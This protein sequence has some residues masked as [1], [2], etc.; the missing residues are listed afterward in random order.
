MTGICELLD[1]GDETRPYTAA[2]LA[3]REKISDSALTPSARLLAELQAGGEDFFA[4]G[5]RIARAHQDYFRSLPAPNAGRLAEF[6]EEARESHAK[7]AAMEAAQTG[8]FED[9]LADWFARI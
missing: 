8:T 6:E 9:Y 4:A 7:Q 5:L 3:Q 2:L 1:A